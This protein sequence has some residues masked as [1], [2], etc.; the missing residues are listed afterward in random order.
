MVMRRLR[1][2]NVNRGERREDIRERRTRT[3]RKAEDVLV[4]AQERMPLAPGSELGV[5]TG[6]K[7]PGD[8]GDGT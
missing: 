3:A 8:R 1:G 5:A 2:E 7:G 4:T 6:R